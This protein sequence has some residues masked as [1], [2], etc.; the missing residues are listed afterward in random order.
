MTGW[1]AVAALAVA[2]VALLVV[3]LYVVDR[4]HALERETQD[5]ARSLEEARARRVQPWAGLSG[6]AL[7]QALAGEPPE[8]TDELALEAVRRRY[9]LVLADHVGHL[10]RL[11]RAD[12]AS[13]EE[14]TPPNTR[15]V[16]TPRS[17]VESWL[18]PALA[19]EVYACGLGLA[20]LAPGADDGALRG[21]LD[22]AV[23]QL[24]LQCGLEPGPPA[25]AALLQAADG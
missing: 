3:V 7:W 1:L 25:S 8:G 16:R 9:R 11:G 22:A 17:Q 23:A 6:E 19:A 2:V 13:G 5:V 15:T 4:V 18:P 24:H 14:R 20:R 21:R 10:L 12:A